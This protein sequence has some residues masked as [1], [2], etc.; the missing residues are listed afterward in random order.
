MTISKLGIFPSH[1]MQWR[2]W[3]LSPL[4][5]R[6]NIRKIMKCYS[7]KLWQFV[8]IVHELTHVK[9]LKTLN[10]HNIH[11]LPFLHLEL[12]LNNL[13]HVTL[14]FCHVR[15]IPSQVTYKIDVAT[16]QEHKWDGTMAFNPIFRTL[17]WQPLKH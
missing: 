3:G 9:G 15:P 6:V 17:V 11:S 5:R 10:L 13:L 8:E 2:Y 12:W 16:F 14:K 7:S 1:M 4:H